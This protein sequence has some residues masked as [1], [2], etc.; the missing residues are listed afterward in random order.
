MLDEGSK[1]K[2]CAADLIL[3]AR[4]LELQQ[5]RTKARSRRVDDSH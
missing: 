1:S 4:S 2:A 3:L 5:R